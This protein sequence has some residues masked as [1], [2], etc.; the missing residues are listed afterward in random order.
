S[1]DLPADIDP[2]TGVYKMQ[3][4]QAPG[5]RRLKAAR[6][7]QTQPVPPAQGAARALASMQS[8]TRLRASTSG[9]LVD[10]IGSPA[11][12]HETRRQTAA[13]RPAASALP[14]RRVTGRYSGVPDTCPMTRRFAGSHGILSDTPI[15]PP[16]W[17][18]EAQPAN[19]GLYPPCW[20]AGQ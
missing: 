15:S 8:H 14:G 1:H 3:L 10:M 17:R 18:V 7:A 5:D 6:L 9:P 16:T 19:R 11:K 20:F 2:A 4:P 12:L 13:D